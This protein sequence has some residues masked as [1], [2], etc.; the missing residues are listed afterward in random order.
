[1]RGHC[2]SKTKQS[3]TS[4]HSPLMFA[5]CSYVAF[6]YEAI[7]KHTNT[8]QQGIVKYLQKQQERGKKHINTWK[9]EKANVF[10]LGAVEKS[11]NTTN[12]DVGY[13]EGVASTVMGHSCADKHSQL[14][15][16]LKYSPTVGV[17]PTIFETIILVAKYTLCD[18]SLVCWFGALLRSFSLIFFYV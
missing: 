10:T 9:C 7:K 16:S 1:M 17:L 5:N 13:N 6:I 8:A 15:L 14:S 18:V 11:T 4:P 3:N 12:C 2:N